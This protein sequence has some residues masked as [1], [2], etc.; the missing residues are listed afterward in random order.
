[1][2]SLNFSYNDVNFSVSVEQERHHLKINALGN[3]YKI[4]NEKNVKK[5]A[6]KI[7]K[8]IGVFTS[9]EEKSESKRQLVDDLSRAVKKVSSVL[10]QENRLHLQAK[11]QEELEKERQQTI[12]NL[13]SNSFYRAECALTKRNPLWGYIKNPSYYITASENAYLQ[14]AEDYINQGFCEKAANAYAKA[15]QLTG[16]IGKLPELPDLQRYFEESYKELVRRLPDDQKALIQKEV[17]SISN[18]DDCIHM[19]AKKLN[20]LDFRFLFWNDS[21]GFPAE[22]WAY[23]ALEGVKRG[24]I[25]KDQ[26]A[27]AMRILSLKKDY[28]YSEIE[29]IP[30]SKKLARE[31]VEETMQPMHSINGKICIDKDTDPFLNP[32]QLESMF[33]QVDD[34]FPSEQCIILV[35]DLIGYNETISQFISF[36]VGFNVLARP[37]K[38]MG[39]K[40]I[41][42]TASLEKAFLRTR[43]KEPC[44]PNYVL[45]KSNG[46]DIRANGLNYTRDVATPFI[47]NSLPTKADG[48]PARQEIDFIHHD[49]FHCYSSSEVGVNAPF[50][51]DIADHI[52]CVERYRSMDE[53]A[54][55][56]RFALIDLDFPSY[57]HQVKNMI[58]WIP[59][60][61]Q[62]SKEATLWYCISSCALTSQ[63]PGEDVKN[64]LRE[65]TL[66]L[67]NEKILDKKSLKEAAAHVRF[68]LDTYK[69]SLPSNYQWCYNDH[70]IFIMLSKAVSEANI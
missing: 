49:Y 40:R 60:Q 20:K 69:E 10:E 35:K 42:P 9:S 32:I 24:W 50:F 28:S 3:N 45:G 34:A 57:R 44:L 5:V 52:L 17:A 46:K 18:M 56:F 54:K 27:T 36:S 51:I 7:L 26:F 23:I 22:K 41:I 25:T 62:I 30:L 70:P 11:E 59:H 31:L 2:V 55:L 39:K 67:L 61:N 14:L 58:G 65:V 37:Y 47:Y 38:Y 29:V 1:M 15:I 43:Y 4:Y 8:E 13:Q 66:Y 33:E 16:F 64:L 53:Q 19:F 48:R 68:S 12:H 63:A 21:L 6:A